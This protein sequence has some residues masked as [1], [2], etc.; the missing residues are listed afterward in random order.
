MICDILV[1]LVCSVHMTLVADTIPR[2]MCQCQFMPLSQQRHM[3]EAGA[4][5]DGW[6]HAVMHE[7]E[8]HLRTKLAGN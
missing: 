3:L 1:L 7:D 2:L 6:E 4:G 8:L 5:I